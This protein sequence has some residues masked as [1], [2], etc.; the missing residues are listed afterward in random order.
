MTDLL[1]TDATVRTFDPA[2]PWAEAVGITAGR[3]TYVGSTADAPPAREVRDLNGALVTPGIIDSHNHLL[4]GFDEDAVS[5]EGADTL[6]EV[7]RRLTGLADAR[8]DLDWV[9]G[10]NAVYSIVSGRRPDSADLAGITDRPV[11]VTTY[12]QHSVWLNDVALR[13]L[14]IADGGQIAWGRP[15][16]NSEGRPTGWVTDF[17]TSAMTTAGL[18]A[19]RRDI[20]LYSPDRRYRRMLSSLR[21]A[22]ATGI[23][24]A[25]EPQVPL[26]EMDLMLRARDEGRLSSRVIAALFHPIDAD[27]SFRARLRE[28]VDSVAEHPLL[29]FG[30]L[31]L[32]ADD[33]IEPHTAWMLD[34]YANRP[35]HRGH[36]SAAVGELTRIVTELDAMGFQTHTHATGDGGVRLALDAIEQAARVNGTHDRRHG[37]V[38]VEC[39][40]PDDLP[41]FAQLGVT[42]A[43]QPRHCSPDLVAGTWMEN[44]GEERW[45]RAWRIRSLMDDGAHVALSSDWQVGE[46]DPRVGFYS[47]LTRAGLQGGDGWTAS[48]RIGLD[49]ALRG[50]TREGAWAWHADGDLGVIRV[51]ASADVVAWSDDLYRHEADPAALLD[52]HAALTVVAGT[53]VHETDRAGD[54]P[55]LPHPGESSPHCSAEAVGERIR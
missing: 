30:P 7:R 36:P 34:D 31:K 4:L 9:C 50:Y 33:V 32:Y 43:M 49:D 3:I 2:Q 6:A 40:H 24:T 37:I 39:L 46:M 10:E 29:R 52:Q 55:S 23:T 12:D 41:R 45:D 42:A 25:V 16:L 47:A 20:P 18:D 54:R 27:A 21:M 22:T 44:V 28:A 13:V 1:L 17:Y 51:G 53:V 14:G 26:A 48:E 5:L 15:E 35:G 8:P 11:F 38:H 19:L